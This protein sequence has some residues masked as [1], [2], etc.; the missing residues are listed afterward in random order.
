M[1][2]RCSNDDVGEHERSLEAQTYHPSQNAK[3]EKLRSDSISNI[4]KEEKGH[5]EKYK[6]LFSILSGWVSPPKL[7]IHEQD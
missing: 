5:Q 4:P 2:K 6:R 7:R 1:P 3:I